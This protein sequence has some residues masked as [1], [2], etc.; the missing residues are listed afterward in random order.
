MRSTRLTHDH[1]GTLVVF[2]IGMTIT[3]PWRPDL[4]LPVFTAMPR[5]L[6]ELEAQEHSGLLG[7]EYLAMR[8]GPA[9]LQYWDSQEAL[10]AYAS[11]PEGRHL[12]AW[13]EFHRRTRK[14][15]GAVGIWHETYVVDRAES[16]YNN[17]RAVGL[18]RATHVVPVTAARLTGA[19]R[20]R[21]HRRST[22]APQ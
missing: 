15:P 4:W 7:Y 1:D 17:T 19:Q 11:A 2:L 22:S 8:T 6:R 16:V 5:M 10:Y 20:F 3:K 18:S 13:R 14:H 9:V 21:R 12:S